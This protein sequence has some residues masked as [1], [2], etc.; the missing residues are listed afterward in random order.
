MTGG[1]LWGHTESLKWEHIHHP[2]CTGLC[3][4]YAPTELQNF[5]YQAAEAENRKMSPW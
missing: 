4:P 2:W 1:T 3:F 5:K